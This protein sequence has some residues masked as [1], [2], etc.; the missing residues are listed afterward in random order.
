VPEKKKQGILSAHASVKSALAKVGEIA[1]AGG[2]PVSK[3]C[4]KP[5]FFDPLGLTSSEKHIPQ[6]DENT[7]RAKWL[8]DALESV[9]MR[10]RQWNLW[11]QRAK[12]KQNTSFCWH[13]WH[14]YA[15]EQARQLGCINETDPPRS[16]LFSKRR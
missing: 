4:Q 15:Q 11:K 9:A 1:R 2:L 13:S 8:L 10:P 3:V 12:W 14:I 6:G 16:A 5:M 7:E